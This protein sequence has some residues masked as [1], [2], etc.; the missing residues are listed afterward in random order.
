MLSIALVPGPRAD[1]LASSLSE[2]D[3]HAPAILP[4]EIANVLR[5][6]RLAGLLSADAARS[7][8]A[9]LSRLPVELWPFEVVRSRVWLLADVMGAYDASY[10]A[11]A[12]HLGAR[13]V[14][15]DRRLARAPGVR[16]DVLVPTD[17]PDVS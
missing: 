2:S 11:L 12:E 6:R 17:R 16:C 3:L 4:F 14:T 7:V 9:N 5:R 8:D 15:M 10:V 1:E 13:L